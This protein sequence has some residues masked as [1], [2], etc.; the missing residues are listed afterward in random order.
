MIRQFLH[1]VSLV[2]LFSM[3][4]LALAQET[5][6]KAITPPGQVVDEVTSTLIAIAQSDASMLENDPAAYFSK[7]E[8]VL[9][10]AVDFK[11]I[12]K[13]VMGRQ[14]W[15]GATEAQRE[16]FAEVFTDSLVETYGKGMANF[17]DFDIKVESARISDK[18]P[19]IAYVMQSVKTNDGVNKIMYTM[20]KDEAGWRL[21]NVVLDGINLGKTFQSQFA[22]AVKDSD[23]DV[24]LAI[25]NWGVD[26][27]E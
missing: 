24:E 3:A 10:E 26:T 4:S 22:Q 6:E 11:S 1:S 2:F 17:A 19:D 16:K 8:G 7:I 18:N 15:P 12:S 27:S 23:G 5:Q 9:V 14:Y 21:R 25:N 20:R 13:S